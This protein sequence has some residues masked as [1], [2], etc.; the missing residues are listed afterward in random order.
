MEDNSLNAAL[1]Q[2]SLDTNPAGEKIIDI[3][4]YFNFQC[5]EILISL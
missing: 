1:E 5:D 2:A 3:D 4:I